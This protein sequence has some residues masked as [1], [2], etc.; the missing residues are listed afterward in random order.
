MRRPKMLILRR[1]TPRGG[2]LALR[3]EATSV[4]VP[5]LEETSV[6]WNIIRGF[7]VVSE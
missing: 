6:A 4:R 2:G 3:Y 7:F 5:P 1:L